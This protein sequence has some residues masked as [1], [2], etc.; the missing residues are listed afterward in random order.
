MYAVQCAVVINM[1]KLQSSRVP[2]LAVTFGCGKS[3]WPSREIY[4]L[5]NLCYNI[6][7]YS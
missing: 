6:W 4:V 7:A 3:Q 1:V 5:F 2:L